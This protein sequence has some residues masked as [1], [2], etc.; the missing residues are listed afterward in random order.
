MAENSNIH[1]AMS[2]E[3]YDKIHDR[4]LDIVNRVTDMGT[5]YELVDGIGDGLETLSANQGF[6]LPDSVGEIV[7]T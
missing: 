4:T 2:T 3:I 6:D 5:E 1:Y 7:P